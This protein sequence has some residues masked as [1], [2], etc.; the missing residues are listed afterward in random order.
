MP[1]H[2]P[3]ANF[4]YDDSVS[5]PQIIFHTAFNAD[6]TKVS[7]ATDGGPN[8]L[9]ASGLSANRDGVCSFDYQ[10]PVGSNALSRESDVG[11]NEIPPNAND[12]S[13]IQVGVDR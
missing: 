5:P 1:L 2:E 7:L 6:S 11:G 10:L 12:I 3:K 13:I 8:R 9:I 4:T